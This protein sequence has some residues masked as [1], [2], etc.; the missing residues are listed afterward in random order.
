MNCSWGGSPQAST[1]GLVASQLALSSTAWSVGVP[2]AIAEFYRN[3]ADLSI[4]NHDDCVITKLGAIRLALRPS[5]RPF[6]YEILSAL[7]RMWHHGIALCLPRSESAMHGRPAITEIGPDLDA[8]RSEDRASILFDLGLAHPF[9]DFLVRVSDPSQ[10]ARMRKGV[11]RS[12]FDLSH[13]L[14]YEIPHWSPHRVFVSRLARI[15]V[16]QRIGQAGALTPT[17]PHTHV[18]PKLFRRE[19]THSSNIRIPNEWIPCVTF[20]PANPRSDSDGAIKDF[21]AEEHRLFQSLHSKYGEVAAIDTKRNV[22]A[23]IRGGIAPTFSERYTR[24]H[25]IACRVALRQ[26]FF[27]DGPSSLLEDWSDMYDR[28]DQRNRSGSEV[29]IKCT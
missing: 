17:G 29:S 2:G 11:G 20:Y 3:P 5:V 13:G 25:R 12:L 6:S 27:M 16:F 28:S 7:P 9:F 18:L 26:L 8:I 15:E 10:I 1:A 14:Y 4:G 19:R 21:D 23:A 24:I 22:W